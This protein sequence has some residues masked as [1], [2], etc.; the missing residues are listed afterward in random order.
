MGVLKIHFIHSQHDPH[1][2]RETFKKCSNSGEAFIQC[3]MKE[4]FFSLIFFT[5]PLIIFITL[6]LFLIFYKDNFQQTMWEEPIFRQDKNR[7]QSA[8]MLSDGSIEVF[9]LPWNISLLAVSVTG[10][11]IVYSLEILVNTINSDSQSKFKAQVT[12]IFHITFTI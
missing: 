8:D 1:I 3:K 12:P 4:L 5:I 6:C 10:D 9:T 7:R 2:S 11:C